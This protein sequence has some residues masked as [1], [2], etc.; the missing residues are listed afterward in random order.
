MDNGKVEQRMRELM[1]P[2]D[3][4]LMMC[5]SQEDTM[6]M[7]CAMMQRCFEVFDHHLTPEGADSILLHEINK[8]MTERTMHQRYG[9]RYES[10]D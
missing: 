6:M 3:R 9:D 1:E 7:A 5:D 4:Q 10:E 8:R 2:V